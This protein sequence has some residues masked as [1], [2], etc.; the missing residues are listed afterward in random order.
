MEFYSQSGFTLSICP[1]VRDD[2]EEKML[3]L[4]Y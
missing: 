2:S 3:V 1:Q 4:V